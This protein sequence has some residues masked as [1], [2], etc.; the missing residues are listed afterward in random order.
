MKNSGLAAVLS[1]FFAGL[2]QIYNGQIGKGV[3]FIVIQGV[4]LL[5]M[6]I[7]VGFI[8]YPIVWIWGMMDAYKTAEKINR[9]AKQSSFVQEVK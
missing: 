9:S 1:F 4:N 8:T 6:F 2:G 3:L 7:I 5:L